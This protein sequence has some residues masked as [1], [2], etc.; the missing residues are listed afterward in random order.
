MTRRK[1]D[2][3][4]P[5]RFQRWPGLILCVRLNAFSK[6]ACMDV[7]SAIGWV[8]ENIGFRPFGDEQ[9]NYDFVMFVLIVVSAH[10]INPGHNRDFESKCGY[11]N[12]TR[13]FFS[14][15]KKKKRSGHA[16]LV[17][18]YSIIRTTKKTSV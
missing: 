12:R 5:T 14:Q 4:D 18:T 15:M 6:Y 16:R 8:I 17:P 9:A 7:K 2:P 1:C 13:P 11:S 3:D 10:R